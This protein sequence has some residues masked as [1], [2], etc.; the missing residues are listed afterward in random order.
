M[1][2]IGPETLNRAYKNKA[3][4]LT[5]LKYPQNS[6]NNTNATFYI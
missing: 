3:R 5:L 1:Y 4:P 2:I 6:N